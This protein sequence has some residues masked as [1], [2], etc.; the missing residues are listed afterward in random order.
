VERLQADCERLEQAVL[1]G[2]IARAGRYLASLVLGAD[3]DASLVP[4]LLDYMH[5]LE[6]LVRPLREMLHAALD[7]LHKANR[8]IDRLRAENRRLRDDL[9]RDQQGRVA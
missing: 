3:D 9:R 1:D 8:E 4:R 5:E 2:R 7:L 6:A